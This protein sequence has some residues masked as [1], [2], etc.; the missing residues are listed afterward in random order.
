M[1]KNAKERERTTDREY[2]V[3]LIFVTCPN[4]F[5]PENNLSGSLCHFLRLRNLTL[6]SYFFG[7]FD[8]VVIF[9][10][11]KRLPLF[12]GGLIKLICIISGRLKK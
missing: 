7:S 5:H 11:L 12:W 1:E 3:G 9:V 10:G 6:F 2:K 8:L 4:I